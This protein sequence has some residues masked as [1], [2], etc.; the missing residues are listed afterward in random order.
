[1]KYLLVFILGFFLNNVMRTYYSYLW[2]STQAKITNELM[3]ESFKKH[4]Y[5]KIVYDKI[6]I[7]DNI[8]YILVYGNYTFEKWE[9]QAP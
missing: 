6:G 4:G 3:N 9:L 1:M 8:K 2:W 7:Q 5:Y